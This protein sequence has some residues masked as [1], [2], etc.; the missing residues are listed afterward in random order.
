MVH[1]GCMLCFAY[2]SNMC[3][4][5]LR[6]RVPSAAPVRVAR[7][8]SHSLRFHKRS[9]KDGSGKADAYF[10][11]EPEDLVWG[12]VFD[13]DPAEKPRLDAHEGLG[14]GYVERLVTVI[15]LAGG[16]HPAFTYTAEAGHIDRTLRPYSWYRRF[17]VEGARQHDLPPG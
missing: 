12:V 6:Q 3:T 11:G 16:M 10:T 5:R 13:I 7:L 8:L 17:V 15:D 1:N 4:G 14:H 2:G 9:D